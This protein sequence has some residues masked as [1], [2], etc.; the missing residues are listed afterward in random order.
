MQ[1]KKINPDIVFTH[2]END[3]NIDHQIVARA[4][5]IAFRPKYKEIC[6]KILSFEIPSSTDYAAYRNKIFQPNYYVDIEKTFKKKM[7][8]CM[9]YKKELMNSPNSRSKKGL[10]ILANF[11]GSQVGILKA[12]SFK[13]LRALD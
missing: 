6:K 10:E 12:E 3:L 8:A 4:T 7:K 5:M 9:V 2:F 11:R 13:I 1:K